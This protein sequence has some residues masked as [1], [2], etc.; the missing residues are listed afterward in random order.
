MLLILRLASN[1]PLTDLELKKQFCQ[2]SMWKT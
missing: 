1:K 2:L